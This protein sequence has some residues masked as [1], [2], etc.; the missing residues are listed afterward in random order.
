[1][2]ALKNRRAKGTGGAAVAVDPNHPLGRLLNDLQ[3]HPEDVGVMENVIDDL[4]DYQPPLAAADIEELESYLKELREPLDRGRPGVAANTYRFLVSFVT[5]LLA[6]RGGARADPWAGFDFDGG[7]R[8]SQAKRFGSCVKAVRKTVKARKGSSKESAAIAICTTTLLHPRGR[9][10][11]RYRK[12]RLLT[13]RR[14]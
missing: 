13:Q 12:G 14:R 7:R 3:T 4:I 6:R 5:E 2:A 11:K 9:T 8:K 1:M 10:I